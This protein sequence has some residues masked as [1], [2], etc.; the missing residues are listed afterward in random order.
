MMICFYRH[1]SFAEK[2]I[3]MRKI[4]FILYS[5]FIFV[6]FF[7]IAEAQ[8]PLLN[9]TYY[10]TQKVSIE[11]KPYH[12]FLNNKL[13]PF[14]YGVASGDPLNDRVIIW[15][16]VSPETPGPIAV[17]WVI[18]TDIN[19]EHVVNSGTVTTDSTIDYTVKVDADGL[20]AGTY[21]YYGFKALGKSSLTG[22]TKTLPGDHVQKLTFAQ[23][24]CSNYQ[25]G[26][27][28]AYA[29][30]SERNDIDA[31]IF[32][33]DYIY[34]YEAG[35]Y[36]YTEQ[37]SDRAHFPENEILSLSDYRNRYAQYR[38]DPD[39][40]RCHQQYPWIMVWDDHETADNSWKGGANNHQTATEGD[41]YVR[42]DNAIRAYYEWM[43]VRDRNERLKIYRDFA[44]G[45][46][47]HIIV[48]ESRLNARDIQVSGTSDTSYNSPN[49][50][51]LGE[52]E[53][54]WFTGKLS[55]SAC[56][57]KIIGNQVVMAQWNAG[58]NPFNYDA[59]D[60][61]P[62]QRNRLF[63]YIRQ[64]KINNMV[65]L[66]GDIHSS[67]ANDLVENPTDPTM[68]NPVTGVGAIGVEFVGTSIT[69]A[70]FD[71]TL[72]IPEGSATP[73][74]SNG[75]KS[76]NPEIKYLQLDSNGYV[77]I[78]VDQDKVQA[79]FYCVESVKEHTTKQ[80]YSTSWLV[81]DT[82]NHLEQTSKP[83]PTGTSSPAPA[84]IEPP[85]SV[86]GFSSQ[87]FINVHDFVCFPNPA[88]S[89][90]FISYFLAK[91]DLVSVTLY[92]R[93]GLS[94]QNIQEPSWMN[95]ASCFIRVNTA[96]LASGIYFCVIRSGDQ[97]LA[98]KVIVTH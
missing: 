49:R 15:T 27:F 20:Q 91:K 16:R 80:H 19:L 40:S 90:F 11:K 46:L 3:V 8:N 18:A 35:G 22:R 92:N 36:G 88:K 59:W 41:W 44:F 98:Q 53:M 32:L 76:N 82:L 93:L 37:D 23:V 77:I 87:Q 50:E 63:S 57:W 79:D 68:Y 56:K 85:G 83:V 2:D 86:T 58:N 30:I 69:S 72:G 29:R 9:T 54:E 6:L 13:A 14:Y 64:N 47:A 60:G 7:L 5:S 74:L 21:Y 48:I 97:E 26:Y 25:A 17:D 67:W 28:N 24:S 71:E 95:P 34:E 4:N 65:V 45:K 89:E 55:S 12:L 75:I 38:T 70:N 10:Q 52:E 66:T 51:L 42:R 43:P 33:G 84:P 61:Y 96:E 78:N 94:V 81:R 31:V 73:S 62:V 1:H 39:L